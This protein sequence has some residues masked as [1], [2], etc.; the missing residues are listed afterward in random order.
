[1]DVLRLGAGQFVGEA[2]A[3]AL[4]PRRIGKHE[5]TA[6]CVL[7]MRRPSQGLA[8]VGV[9]ACVDR[10]GNSFMR[11]H[12][13]RIAVAC[14]HPIQERRSDPHFA[15]VVAVGVVIDRLA[16]PA[17]PQSVLAGAVDLQFEQGMGGDIAHRMVIE[18]NAMT[19]FR[20]ASR[21]MCPAHAEGF[22]LECAAMK[23]VH[24]AM[25]QRNV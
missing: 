5:H 12:V 8:Q 19:G 23:C 17:Q 18:Y 7:P 25:G 22:A 13:A 3:H 14:H 9:G 10:A 6:S 1:M 20:G 11:E 15:P 21:Y 4:A 24:E 2:A 16:E